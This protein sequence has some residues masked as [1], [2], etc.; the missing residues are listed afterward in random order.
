MKSLKVTRATHPATFKKCKNLGE[1][2]AIIEQEGE[3]E[4]LYITKVVLNGRLMDEEE[5]KLLDS[6]SINEVQE[7]LVQMASISE[8]VKETLADS[9]YAIQGAQSKA[10]EFA[11]SFR[12]Q[13]EVDDEKIKYVL[14][15]CRQIIN[16][17]E[18]VFSAH[19]NERL[20]LKHHSLW[21]EAEKELTN[22]LQCIFQARQMP[23][24]QL[25]CDLLEYDLVQALDQWE[26]V[27]EKEL[28]EN[29]SLNGIFSLKN[30][31]HRGDNEVDV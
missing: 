27:I 7:M 25:V 24:Y 14:I 21:I 20:T 30:Q 1:L 26:E 8:I 16:S 5:E 15:Q 19:Q 22:I 10:I 18:E 29:S 3:L 13:F 9:L 28:L 31:S 6:L 4:N 23:G 11:K 17:L 12:A 2:I